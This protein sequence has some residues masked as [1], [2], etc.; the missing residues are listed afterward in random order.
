[1]SV[2]TDDRMTEA[3]HRDRKRV[4]ALR[5]AITAL[6]YALEEET[7]MADAQE[8]IGAKLKLERRAESL[9]AAWN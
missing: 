3:Y 2:K 6:N 8:Y 9:E 4:R 7:S 1:M 5:A